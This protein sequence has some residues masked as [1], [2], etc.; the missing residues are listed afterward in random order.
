MADLKAIKLTTGIGTHDSCVVFQPLEEFVASP[1][2]F[3]I[4]LLI[5][6]V[7]VLNNLITTYTNNVC[8]TFLPFVQEYRGCDVWR[9]R[10][11][12]VVVFFGKCMSLR[13]RDIVKTGEVLRL[14]YELWLHRR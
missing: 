1:Y 4:T 9:L 12:G 13:R 3:D 7:Y 10:D 6:N 5:W 8:V 14:D 11:S 2:A